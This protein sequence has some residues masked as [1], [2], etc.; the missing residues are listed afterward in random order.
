MAGIGGGGV[1]VR[2]RML[3]GEGGFRLEDITNLT[4]SN[5]ILQISR[6]QRLHGMLPARVE[7]LSARRVPRS[8]TKRNKKEGRRTLDDDSWLL[9]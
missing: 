1:R 9:T 7:L 4:E 5:Q 8:P 3:G 6:H 2:G